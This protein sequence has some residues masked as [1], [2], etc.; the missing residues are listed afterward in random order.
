MS[1]LCPRYHG[2]VTLWSFGIGFFCLG[3]TRSGSGSPVS[4]SN[5]SGLNFFGQDI[6][7]SRT[8]SDNARLICCQHLGVFRVPGQVDQ[9]VRVGLHVV[10]FLG[11]PGA[12]EARPL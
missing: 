1:R 4:R 7:V 3:R 9:L 11:G 5:S 10:K 2:L 12:H 6:S 8:Q